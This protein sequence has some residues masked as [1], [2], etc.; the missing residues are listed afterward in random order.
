MNQNSQNSRDKQSNTPE[1]TKFTKQL[2]Q[3]LERSYSR[4]T[5][6]RSEQRNP[7]SLFSL[8][9]NLYFSLSR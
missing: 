7:E 5:M 3:G 1:L 8:L 2:Y 4:D 6:N 9:T